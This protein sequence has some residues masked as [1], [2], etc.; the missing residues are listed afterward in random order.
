MA[1]HYTFFPAECFAIP[2]NQDH[3]WRRDVGIVHIPY[4]MTRSRYRVQARL[5]PTVVFC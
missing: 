3:Y 1:P 2:A 4:N 5:A